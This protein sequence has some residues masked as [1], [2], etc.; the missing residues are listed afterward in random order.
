MLFPR[1][2][3]R[4]ELLPHSREHDR[5]PAKPCRGLVGQ[6]FTVLPS[7]NRAFITSPDYQV[8]HSTL[9]LGI[10]DGHVSPQALSCLPLPQTTRAAS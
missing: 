1:P 2:A 4:L 9:F 8:G 7:L 10:W 5:L 6:L 3:P